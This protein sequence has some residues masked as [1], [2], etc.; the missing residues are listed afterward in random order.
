M[1]IKPLLLNISFRSL[2]SLQTI[3]LKPNVPLVPQCHLTQTSF[4]H[5]LQLF[6]FVLLVL[7]IQRF[8]SFFLPLKVIVNRV[9]NLLRPL[10]QHLYLAMIHIYLPI[11]FFQIAQYL[12]VTLILPFPIDNRQYI[13]CFIFLL[14]HSLLFA[15]IYI[16]SNR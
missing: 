6:I 7:P 8:Q 1:T 10:S 11:N 5:F 15:F 2:N 3:F 13:R 16:L 4:L 12:I 14:I 9:F